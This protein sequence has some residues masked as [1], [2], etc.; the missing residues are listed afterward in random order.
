MPSRLRTSRQII[1]ERTWQDRVEE[2]RR[3]LLS[4]PTDE[5]RAKLQH[6]LRI[7]AELVEH[8]KV[9]TEPGHQY[10]IAS[11]FRLD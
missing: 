2:A 9:P 4:H 6:L 11:V 7:F 10:L 1:L 3:D 5:A 8:G